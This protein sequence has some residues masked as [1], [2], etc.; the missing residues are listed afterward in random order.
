MQLMTADTEAL[1]SL[2]AWFY[3]FRHH[4]G[5]T[6]NQFAQMIGS[7]INSIQRYEKGLQK[8]SNT[9][10]QFMGVLAEAHDFP[11]PP[12]TTISRGP[13]RRDSD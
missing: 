4:M 9:V 12:I 13:R 3:E 10:L 6:Q 11:A 1:N 2:P 7:T 5:L 8:P